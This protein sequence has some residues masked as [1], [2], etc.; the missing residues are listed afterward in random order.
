MNSKQKKLNK[1]YGNVGKSATASKFGCFDFSFPSLHFQKK[2][3]KK[4]FSPRYTC[5]HWIF[6]GVVTENRQ[7]QK[8]GGVTTQ[9]ITILLFQLDPLFSLYIISI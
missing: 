7:K 3:K 1:F 6:F 8:H 5:F 2:K 4:K 9:N